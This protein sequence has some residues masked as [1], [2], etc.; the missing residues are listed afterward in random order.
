M[1]T[2]LTRKILFLL[3]GTLTLG[4]I[5]W[6]LATQGPLAPIK[7]TVTRVASGPLAT[8]VFGIGTIDALR[9]YTLGP[10]TPGRVAELHVEQGD[11]V[12]QGA[13]LARMDAVDLHERLQSAELAISKARHG[14]RGA[15]AQLEEAKSRAQLAAATQQRYQEMRAQNFVSVEALEAK[16]YEA[17]AA[18]AAMEAT[19]QGLL[20]ARSDLARSESDIAGL[21]KQLAQLTLL[22]PVDGVVIARLVEPGT[23]VVAGQAVVELIDPS[24]LWVSARIDQRQAGMVRLGQPVDIVLRSQPG[25]RHPGRVAR[26]DRVSDA[27]TEERTVHIT[28]TTPD[29]G[30]SLGELVEVTIHQP[31]LD[32]VAW[33]PAAAIRRSG[34]ESGVWV[35]TAGGAEFT[36]VTVGVTTLDGRSQLLTPLDPALPVVVHTQQAL[37]AGATV[38]VVDALLAP[39]P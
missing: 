22:S 4:A 11:R 1:H 10:T 19:A 5:G 37:T 3:F 31:Q 7:V 16:R 15:E 25:I 21:Q 12:L 33:L 23:T 24:S 20:A 29:E 9:R 39:R 28:F 13:V 8:E 27:V 36:P 6:V 18:N 26:I 38:R 14:V 32:N 2:T 35:V 34:S 30:L 17:A